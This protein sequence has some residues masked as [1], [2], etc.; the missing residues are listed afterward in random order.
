MHR[1]GT[2]GIAL[3]ALVAAAPATA[4]SFSGRI[5]RVELKASLMRFH[6]REANVSLYASGALQDLL[7]RAFFAKARIQAEYQPLP[8]GGGVSGI[9]G[10]V[11]AVTVEQKDL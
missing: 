1:N 5:D 10:T 4:E 2:L 11:S 7:L 6:A 3:V 8:C 9:C